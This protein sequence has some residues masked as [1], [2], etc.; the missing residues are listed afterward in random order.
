MPSLKRF[1]KSVR[2]LVL[3]Y[4]DIFTKNPGCLDTN[5]LGKCQRSV[6]WNHWVSFPLTQQQTM[7]ATIKLT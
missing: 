5:T 6:L 2:S 3:I 1:K 7:V 4:C